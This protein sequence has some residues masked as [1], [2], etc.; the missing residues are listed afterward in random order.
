[1]GDP[2][3]SCG[4]AELERNSRTG[5]GELSA[6]RAQEGEQTQKLEPKGGLQ[7]SGAES[8]VGKAGRIYRGA[9][10]GL[11]RLGRLWVSRDSRIL[12]GSAAWLLPRSCSARSVA[13]GRALR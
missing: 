1:M 5:E 7:E 2:S 12:S 13:R 9:A 11:G 8:R 4:A 10:P 6:G 3:R